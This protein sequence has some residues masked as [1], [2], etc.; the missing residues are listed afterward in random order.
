MPGNTKIKLHG[1][2]GLF[3][4]LMKYEMARGCF[5]GE[6]WL[7]VVYPLDEPDFFRIKPISSQK[8]GNAWET[9]G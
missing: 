6:L 1:S 4:N 5:G 7:D 9:V 3:Y 2:F 8:G